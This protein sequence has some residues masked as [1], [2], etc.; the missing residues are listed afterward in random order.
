[1]L[2][3]GNY[4]RYKSPLVAEASPSYLL[5]E[6][7]LEM[8]CGVPSKPSPSKLGTNGVYGRVGG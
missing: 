2:E 3:N 4:V 1:M 8:P 6:L 5:W 7:L